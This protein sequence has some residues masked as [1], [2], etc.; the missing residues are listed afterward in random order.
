M[1]E[2]DPPALYPKVEEPVLICAADDGGNQMEFKRS[3]VQAAGEGLPQGEV[4]W[5]PGSAHDIHVDQPRSLADA[6]LVFGDRST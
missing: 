3:Q 4:L 6:L 1:Y 5:F 2:Q